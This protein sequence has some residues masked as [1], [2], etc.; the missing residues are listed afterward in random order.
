MKMIEL[1][2]LKVYLFILRYSHAN[3]TTK[4]RMCMLFEQLYLSVNVWN[5]EHFS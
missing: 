4:K 1:L 5:I 2:P 3:Y